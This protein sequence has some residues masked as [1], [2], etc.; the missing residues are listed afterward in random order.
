MMLSFADDN[1]QILSLRLAFRSKNNNSFPASTPKKLVDSMLSST[2]NPRTDNDGKP[3][4]WNNDDIVIPIRS[5]DLNILTCN[6]PVAAAQ[7]FH[8]LL[9]A[10]YSIL[11]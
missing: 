11:I 8:R 4:V 2:S 7:I 9:E 10:V 1:H 5:K 3:N 6:N